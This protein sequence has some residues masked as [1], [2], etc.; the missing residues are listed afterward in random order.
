MFKLS[1][2]ESLAGNTTGQLVS[3]GEILSA[4]A[5]HKCAPDSLLARTYKERG[6][7]LVARAN[8]AED[9]EQRQ[10]SFQQYLDQSL[11][12]HSLCKYRM[13]WKRHLACIKVF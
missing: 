4:H 10:A 12:Q 13:I 5:E 7:A 9:D 11:G 2:V 1:L 6:A 3:L 8:S